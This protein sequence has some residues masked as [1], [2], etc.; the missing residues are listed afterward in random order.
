MFIYVDLFRFP[1]ELKAMSLFC[2]AVS[3]TSKIFFPPDEI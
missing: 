3:E 1:L 2:Q